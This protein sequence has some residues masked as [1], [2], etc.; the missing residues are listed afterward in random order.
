MI[1]M[2]KM[3][4]KLIKP[5][6]ILFT[7]FVALF[8]ATGAFASE[9][10]DLWS[11]HGLSSHIS[12][13]DSSVHMLSQ[14]FGP[15][16][17]DIIGGTSVSDKG[18]LFADLLKYWN[19]L[20]ASGASAFITYHLIL[21]FMKSADSGRFLGGE[22]EK[23]GSI[24]RYSLG[25]FFVAPVIGVGKFC[26]MQWLFLWSILVG[27]HAA[28]FLWAK[29][30]TDMELGVTATVPSNVRSDINNIAGQLYLYDMVDKYVSGVLQEQSLMGKNPRYSN[31][32]KTTVDLEDQAAFESIGHAL[33]DKHSYHYLS[34]LSGIL[35]G[36]KMTPS[37]AKPVISGSCSRKFFQNKLQRCIDD[38]GSSDE[39]K[40]ECVYADEANMKH[41]FPT[42]IDSCSGHSIIT[43]PVNTTKGSEPWVYFQHMAQF[44][45]TDVIGEPNYIDDSDTN[46]FAHPM[47]ID[48]RDEIPVA[49]R[50]QGCKE[51]YSLSNDKKTMVGTCGPDP[52][53]AASCGSTAYYQLTTGLE[54]R[55]ML[56]A[57][58][59]RN[60]Q[61]SYSNGNPTYLCSRGMVKVIGTDSKVEG[62][63][64]DNTS[65]GAGDNLD[66]S[67]KNY[68]YVDSY[69]QN[70]WVVS[71]I[72][73][74]SN[75]GSSTNITDGSRS[76]G[77]LSGQNYAGFEKAVL[78]DAGSASAKR[79]D[80]TY[81][82]T[83]GAPH[84]SDAT[85]TLGTENSKEKFMIAPLGLNM[86][87]IPKNYTFPILAGGGSL[88]YGSKK[89][90]GT[91]DCSLYKDA[92]LKP[93]GKGG[94]KATK[95]KNICQNGGDPEHNCDYYCGNI[96][97]TASSEKINEKYY[98]P[99]SE[100]EKTDTNNNTSRMSQ[101]P[102]WGW[103]WMPSP[104]KANQYCKLQCNSG[105]LIKHPPRS[106]GPASDFD[107]D[108]Y[109][110]DVDG[111]TY[112]S[113]CQPSTHAAWF[114][115]HGVY[116]PN[117][118]GGYIKLKWLPHVYHSWSGVFWA[119]GVNVCDA[120]YTNISD[121]QSYEENGRR[122]Y[123]LI[124][125]SQN[126]PLAA[127]Q[128][129]DKHKK[130][131]MMGI[132]DECIGFDLSDPGSCQVGTG[133]WQVEVRTLKCL[134]DKGEAMDC[135]DYAS[136][137]PHGI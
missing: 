29:A 23:T 56:G 36:M 42:K 2:I 50:H 93:D 18:Y 119:K 84:I 43:M 87:S 72:K 129:S 117:G 62:C 96:T 44:C 8:F 106:E 40:V 121:V 11:L 107:T 19:F 132:G 130:C 22:Q 51:T 111:L 54:N 57:Y 83:T 99:W 10:Y 137:F 116:K 112:N 39:L 71:G 101:E 133:D 114:K 49:G 136:K 78:I 30:T 102:I 131:G 91:N 80:V 134:S 46:P 37:E 70:E 109:K 122:I 103:T 5:V 128:F 127:T 31:E 68:S 27:V 12:D 4:N 52:S 124:I 92:G 98:V 88:F 26:A 65:I 86:G 20:I 7:V 66:K 69:T 90:S 95:P 47:N 67:V 17:T 125:P 16:V 123:K 34:N 100:F 25:G 24:L 79:G 60:A 35:I 64:P 126:G 108:D 120:G 135:K 94:C 9:G 89:P 61:V 48:W 82:P 74:N 105:D 81:D 75:K 1:K 45:K 58:L 21:G 53:P 113:S 59:R 110:D 115:G 6:I 14:L 13:P 3:I 28:N 77:V 33:M 97:K 85:Q 55:R 15:F 104:D 41:S 73:F 63:I 38:A 118:T 76:S 32:I